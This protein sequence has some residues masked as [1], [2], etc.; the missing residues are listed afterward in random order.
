MS[1]SGSY[2]AP[3]WNSDPYG[4]GSA[5][6]RGP[7]IEPSPPPDRSRVIRGVVVGLVLGLLVF[8]TGGFLVGRV[9]SGHPQ[10]APTATPTP[11]ALGV[12][13]QSQVALNQPK[14]AG[15]LATISRGWLPYVSGCSRSGTGDGPVLNPGEK[16]RVR[17]TLGGMSAIFVEYG[18]IA[19]R[20]KARVKVL[21][22]NVDARTLT[23]GVGATVERATLSGRTTGNYVEYAYKIVE[24]KR[25]RTVSGLWWDDAGTPVAAYLLAFW[26]EGVGESWAPMR[27][28]WARYA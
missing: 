9:A 16:A 21:G 27:D 8:G 25:T 22:Q 11:S 13:E 20:D 15:S 14:F 4:F 12:Y 19:D 18:S 23:P 1:G 26:T 28:I 3:T 2:D 5:P 6:S 10:P 7:R 17:C 24:D